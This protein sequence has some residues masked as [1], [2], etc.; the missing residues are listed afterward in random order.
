MNQVA[1]LVTKD[2]NF[3]VPWTLH[4]FFDQ[5]RF[6]TKTAA[7]FTLTRGQ[8]IGKFSSLLHDAHAFAATACAGLDQHWETNALR[9]LRQHLWVLVCAVVTRHQGHTGFFHQLF[10]GCL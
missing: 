6:V 1:L 3:N 10:G 7:G 5:H 8:G 4:V 9:C 2:L